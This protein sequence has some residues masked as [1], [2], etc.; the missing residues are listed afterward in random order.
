M[1]GLRDKII[2]NYFGVDYAIVWNIVEDDIPE[3]Q[4]WMNIIIQSETAS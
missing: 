3:L 2:H 4:Q 1:A